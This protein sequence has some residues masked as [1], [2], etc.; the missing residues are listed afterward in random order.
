M[1]IKVGTTVWIGKIYEKNLPAIHRLG[2]SFLVWMRFP[3][4][5]RRPE[6]CKEVNDTAD[7]DHWW[8]P[9]EH[10]EADEEQDDGHARVDGPTHELHD[11]FF[12]GENVV[13]RQEEK[14]HACKTN[15]NIRSFWHWEIEYVHHLAR[16]E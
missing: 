12:R 14:D 4:C 15:E 2:G 13:K 11:F 3:Q 9:A 5:P 7:N 1:W 6:C 8:C 16:N 10:D